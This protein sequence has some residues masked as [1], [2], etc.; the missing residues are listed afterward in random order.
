MDSES[1]DAPTPY[2]ATDR[3]ATLAQGAAAEVNVRFGHRLLGLPG[4]WI[5]AVAAPTTGIT[6]PFS[7]WHYWWQAHYLDAVVDAGIAA[8]RDGDGRGA[9][10]E[11][12]RATALL[13]GLLLRNFGRF[14]NYF[15]D[16]MA[17]LALACD[18][19]SAFCRDVTGKPSRW[20]DF[21][22]G[23]LTRQLRAAQNDVLGGG[24]Y[25]SRKRDFKN[26]PANGSA[27]LHF[28]RIG[29]MGRAQGLIDWLRAELF[30]PE[31]GIYLDGSHPSA[32][33]REVET[34]IYTYNQG[35]ILAALLQLDHPRYV[36]QA[37]DLIDAVV[38]HLTVPGQ[39]IRLEQG[40]DGSLFT[41]ILCRYLALV[42]NDGRLPA[43]SRATASLLVLETAS[44]LTGPAP[45]QLSAAVQ[46]WTI[47][48][49]AA[50]CQRP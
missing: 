45:A 14:P 30:D 5:A 1:A 29:E 22:V 41:G 47:F 36:R 28:A 7:P 19:L 37:A 15:Y 49:A 35:P 40:A 13:R 25:W 46:R 48:A 16:D 11:L 10:T 33:G 44:A 23:S 2:P 27:A 24:I 12:R 21:A 4:T 39:G 9:L 18:R 50:T 32:T 17:W 8:F 6:T 42:A 3:W 38:L 43:D 26:T 31:Q 34:T 20:A